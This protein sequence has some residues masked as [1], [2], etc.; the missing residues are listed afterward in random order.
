MQKSLLPF[1]EEYDYIIIDTP[2]GRDEIVQSAIAAADAVLIPMQ[3]EKFAEKGFEITYALMKEVEKELIPY[4][5]RIYEEIGETFNENTF[6]IPI[7]G[8]LL[9]LVEKQTALTSVCRNGL[10]ESEFADVLLKSEIRKAQLYKDST[11]VLM[12]AVLMEKKGKAIDDFESLY[13]EVK[14]RFK[15]LEDAK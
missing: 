9:T 14:K 11:Y 4:Y 5:K 13:K 1:Q 7:L 10:R 3:C 8:I 2:P 6:E 15:K 12:P